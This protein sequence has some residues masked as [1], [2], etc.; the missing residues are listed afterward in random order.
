MPI[1]SS[2]IIEDAVQIDGR[3]HCAERHTDHL[4]LAHVVRYMAEAGADVAAAMSARVAQLDAQL[5]GQ[6]LQKDLALILS[7]DYAEVTAQYASLSDV[8]AFLRAFYSTATGEQVGRMAGFLLTLTDAQLR[9]LFN[10][11]QTQ[12]NQ[13]KT[14]LQ[15]RVDALNAVLTAAG[16]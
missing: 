7:G 2:V 14:R 4:G 11:T 8:R 5:V 6:E 1:T 16:E 3:R 9:T 15:A 10:M 13:L 12:V